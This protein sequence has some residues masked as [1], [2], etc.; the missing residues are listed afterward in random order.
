MISL[1]VP[2]Y[3]GRLD[4]QHLAADRRPR[5]PGRH[6]RLLRAAP[7]LGE[8]A[9]PA[10]HRARLGGRDRH[11]AASPCPRRTR[12]RPCGRACPSSRSRL[13]TP[14]LA[15]VLA[16]HDVD[17]LVLDLDLL[18]R[19]PVA[20]DLARDQVAAGDLV[21]LLGRVAGE[22][23]H[24]HAVAQRRR[25]RLEDVRRRDEHHVREVERQVEVVVAERRGS[26][27]GRAPRASRSRGRR[28]SRRPSCRSRRS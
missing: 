27:R 21:L 12:A 14:G 25:N 8:V 19:Q 17:H 10:E 26:A 23:D 6:A 13:R 1:P 28:G 16:D 18:G 20:L 15:R 2:A 11:L 22:L 3:V 4:E 9:P 7:R 24:L 5:E